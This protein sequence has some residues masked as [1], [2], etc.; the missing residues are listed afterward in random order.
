MA[1]PTMR[2][3]DEWKHTEV[4][5]WFFN[6]FLQGYADQEAMRNGR[7]DEDEARYSDSNRRTYNAGVV[8]G[9]DF[10]IEIDPYMEDREQ[11]DG[12]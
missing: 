12:E 3:F 9:V 10:A 5:K 11:V 1:Q 6:H 8:A 4:G 7:M 2:E